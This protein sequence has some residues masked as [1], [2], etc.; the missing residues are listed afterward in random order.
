MNAADLGVPP[1]L[2]NEAVYPRCMFPL[3]DER[4]CAHSVSSQLI[5]MLSMLPEQAERQNSEL[6]DPLIHP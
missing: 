6:F 5:K 3:F 1:T 2:V 4:R